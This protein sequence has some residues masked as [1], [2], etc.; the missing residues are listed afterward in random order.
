ML[1]LVMFVKR[2]T[3]LTP[4]QFRDHYEN[5]HAPL[6]SAGMPQIVKYVRNYL[7][8]FPGQPEPP[9]DCVTEM[10]YKDEAGLKETMAW[11][12]SDASQHLHEDEDKFMDRA[13]M[14]A[15]IA[16]ECVTGN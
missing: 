10:W 11:M 2:R 13:A 8:S 5:V 7:T 6:V 9:C 14:V 4:A 16:A 12:R 15:F 3:D 1:K